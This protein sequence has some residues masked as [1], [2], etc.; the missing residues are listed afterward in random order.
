MIAVVK[1]V[2]EIK[3]QVSEW[4]RMGLSVGLVPTM[5][6]LHEGHVSLIKR[7]VEENDRVVV[8]DFV[9]PTQFS[10]S[11]D[12]ETYPRDIEKDTLMCGQAGADVVFNPEADEMYPGDFCSS[13]SMTGLQN[14]LCGKSRPGHFGGVCTVVCKLFNIVSPDRAY[15][16]EKDAQ[17][18]AI[19]RHMVKDL[20]MNV[21]VVGCPT[22]RE[23]DG[24]ARSSRNSYL[25]EEER[26]AAAVLYRA[27]CTGRDMIL[28]GE[29]DCS[30]VT[31]VMKSVIDEEPLAE[32]DYIDI[33]DALT[34][35]KTEAAEGDILM[36][37]AVYIGKTRLID[38][39]FMKI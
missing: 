15:F 7:A 13:V 18:L 32:I 21:E 33:V 19:I 27:L 8:S 30:R 4:K 20:N 16:G 22:V 17:Q 12:L 6:F 25:N 39:M 24:L 5:G 26:R 28:A 23:D 37:M 11:E 9:N 3:K 34:I 14:E 31:A 36:A 38:N 2:S 29:R 35:E 1:T 10:S